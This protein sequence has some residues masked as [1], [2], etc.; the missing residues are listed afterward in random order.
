MSLGAARR[1]QILDLLGVDGRVVASE[2]ATALGV[3]LDTV[4]RDLDELAAAGALRRV[5]GGA[6]PPSPVSPRFV[7]RAG[8]D[9][10]L[11]QSIAGIAI[12]RLLVSG[13]VIALGGGTTIRELA[14]LLPDSLESTVLTSAPDV[15]VDLLDRPGLEVQL[16]GGPVNRET[17][18]VVGVE[19]IEALAGVRPDVCVLGA[20]SVDIDAGVTVMHRDEALVTR[21][22]MRAA[23]RTAVIAAS[24]KLGTAAQWVVGGVDEVDVLVTDADAPADT[25]AS[26]EARG[27]EVVLA[28]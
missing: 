12:E 24:A 27:V 8:Q 4:R 1:E 25:V 14:R 6:L 20:C 23:S 19:A 18:T 15:A 13:Q 11:K 7:D 5:R 16:L 2:L 10:A 22:L 9:V 21:A 26:L 3:S 17:R 28:G